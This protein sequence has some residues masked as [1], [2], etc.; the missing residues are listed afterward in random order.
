MQGYEKTMQCISQKF[1]IVFV[2]I[3]FEYVA[4]CTQ[5]R[6][7]VHVALTCIYILISVPVPWS[8]GTGIKRSGS[9]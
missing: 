3:N 8:N 6:I 1:H 9:H 2:S 5:Y 4:L 7:Y